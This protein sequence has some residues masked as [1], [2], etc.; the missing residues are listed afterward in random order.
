MESLGHI[1]W[2]WVWDVISA[3]MWHLN[4]PRVLP[5]FGTV[6]PDNDR[7]PYPSGKL[8][9]ETP[10]K[11]QLV[12]IH[13]RYKLIEYFIHLLQA[14]LWAINHPFRKKL[15]NPVHK[16]IILL[17][18]KLCIPDLFEKILDWARGGGRKRRSRIGSIGSE[19]IGEIRF[20]I[21]NRLL[22]QA[23]IAL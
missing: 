20:E 6:S 12:S 3:G 4:R 21:V 7:S 2:I 1:R 18:R 9:P 22:C 13:H 10:R 15:F 8:S 11:D 19:M 16:S 17:D 23:M 14:Y 5:S